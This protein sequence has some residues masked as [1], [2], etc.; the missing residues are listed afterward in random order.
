MSASTI[1]PNRIRGFPSP[2]DGGGEGAGQTA[3]VHAQ[4]PSHL[5]ITTVSGTD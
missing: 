3:E 4:G 5:D 1:P 2:P